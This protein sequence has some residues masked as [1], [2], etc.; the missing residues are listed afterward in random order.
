MN[1]LRTTIELLTTSWNTKQSDSPD[2]WVVTPLPSHRE[3]E[4]ERERERERESTSTCG[5]ET[6][7]NEIIHQ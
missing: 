5:N 2:S 7:G 3:G 6:C 1:L 4:R